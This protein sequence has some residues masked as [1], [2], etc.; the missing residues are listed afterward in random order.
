MRAVQLVTTRACFSCYDVR[1]LLK[2]AAEIRTFSLLTRTIPNANRLVRCSRI[3][4]VHRGQCSAKGPTDRK[5]QKYTQSTIQRELKIILAGQGNE[6]LNRR[7]RHVRARWT[8]TWARQ[9]AK[10]RAFIM[11]LLT[12][13]SSIV[14]IVKE[15]HV[16]R[17]G[18]PVRGEEEGPAAEG[19]VSVKTILNNGL[20]F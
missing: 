9:G 16:P 7:Y 5:S 12:R 10:T 6:R 3:E 4:T 11:A 18:R 8:L 20:S 2:H 13:E 19:P 1:L 14:R 17:N 15:F